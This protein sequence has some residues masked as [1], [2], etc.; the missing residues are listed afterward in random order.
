MK[1]VCGNLRMHV[2]LIVF[3]WRF[4]LFLLYLVFLVSVFG[5]FD[6]VPHFL[7]ASYDRI[8]KL[9]ESACL[10]MVCR[11]L[12]PGFT[13]NFWALQWMVFNTVNWRLHSVKV[14][15]LNL[16]WC[17]KSYQWSKHSIQNYQ[18]P[19]PAIHASFTIHDSS[20]ACL[21]YLLKQQCSNNKCDTLWFHQCQPH[22][23]LFF[24]GGLNWS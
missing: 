16:L 2:T 18:Y 5:I 21:S 10:W 24:G 15:I 17:V 12:F 1:S 6:V 4:I 3:P 22:H 7:L 20:I 23:G 13:Q 19:G 11:T 14:K 9:A 8:L